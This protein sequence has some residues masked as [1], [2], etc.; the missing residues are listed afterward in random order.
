MAGPD[1]PDRCKSGVPESGSQGER[2]A[3]L[4]AGHPAQVRSAWPDALVAQPYPR[5][6]ALPDAQRVGLLNWVLQADAAGRLRRLC[7][8]PLFAPQVA[9][10]RLPEWDAQSA[11]SASECSEQ[12]HSAAE[13]RVS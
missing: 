11:V 13:R 6:A 4:G 10:P 9:E 8:C 12:P 3:F 2:S 7:L 5:A 1:V